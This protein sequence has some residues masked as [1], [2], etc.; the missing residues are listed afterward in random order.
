MTRPILTA[1]AL[2]ALLAACGADGPPKPPAATPDK[3][4]VSISGTARIGVVGTL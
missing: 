3:P 1:L 2:L 4:A